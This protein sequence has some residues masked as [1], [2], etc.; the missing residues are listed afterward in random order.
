MDEINCPYCGQEQQIDHDDGQGLEDEIHEQNCGE[1]E[2]TFGFT[3]SISYSYRPVQ[4]PC[5]NG[6]EHDF[7]VTETFPKCMSEMM[8]EDCG[9]RRELT[10]AERLRFEIP[11]I[12]SY[13]DSLY[14]PTK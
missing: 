12:K 2:K 4:L 8:C 14:N 5:A 6:K 1:C 11:T 13:T 9:T 3:T 7:K 10:A